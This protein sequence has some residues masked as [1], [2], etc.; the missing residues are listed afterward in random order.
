MD[1]IRGTRHKITQDLHARELAVQLVSKRLLIIEIVHFQD[2]RFCNYSMQIPKCWLEFWNNCSFTKNT[3]H[4]GHASIVPYWFHCLSHKRSLPCK[5][6]NGNA[7]SA[8]VYSSPIIKNSHVP[9]LEP[10]GN[11]PHVSFP[12]FNTQFTHVLKLLTRTLDYNASENNTIQ[13]C[14]AFMVYYYCFI[15]KSACVSYIHY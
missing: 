5:I 15:L 9:F 7:P 4:A 12:V 1:I 3:S 13:A 2:Q 8:E 11:Y 10:Q 14:H 6:T